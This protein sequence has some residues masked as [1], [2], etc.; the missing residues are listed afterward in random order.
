MKY[1]FKNRK[2]R[3]KVYLHCIP[4][5]RHKLISAKALNYCSR[6]PTSTHNTFT[7]QIFSSTCVGEIT[8]DMPNLYGSHFYKVADTHV[9]LGRMV[10]FE[11]E[12]RSPGLESAQS[13]SFAFWSK[14]LMSALLPCRCWASGTVAV[15]S[16]WHCF[17][18]LLFL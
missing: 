6:T 10:V 9:S 8:M 14:F 15:I 16:A 2:L 13:R 11:R 7:L 5:Q 17:C 12:K 1:G 3:Q 4:S 18:K